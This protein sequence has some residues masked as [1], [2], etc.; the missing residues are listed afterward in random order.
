VTNTPDAVSNPQG[1]VQSKGAPGAS[2]D[3]GVGT[4]LR[5]HARSKHIPQAWG[6]DQGGAPPPAAWLT[7]E[8]GGESIRTLVRH[9]EH[10]DLVVVELVNL[11]FSRNH[12]FR[13]HDFVPCERKRDQFCEKWEAARDKIDR[14]ELDRLA[15]ERRER[16]AAAERAKRGDTSTRGG[17]GK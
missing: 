8:L 16:M 12:S 17:G 5:V 10:E 6:F 15:T 3:G 1:Y 2:A 13:Q 11:P 9:V 7:V 14:A 4:H